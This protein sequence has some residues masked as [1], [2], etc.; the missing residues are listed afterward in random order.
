MTTMSADE[1]YLNLARSVTEAML[2]AVASQQ[3]WYSTQAM[4]TAQAVQLVLS[5]HA[6]VLPDAV[7]TGLDL[8]DHEGDLP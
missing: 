7:A 3:R 5:A 6:T 4:V 2:E 1:V 8:L